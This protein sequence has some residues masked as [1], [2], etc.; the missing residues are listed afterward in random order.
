MDGWLSSD[1]YINELKQEI[2]PSL[3]REDSIYIR[4]EENELVYRVQYSTRAYVIIYWE[5][6]DDT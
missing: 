2:I 1:M 6:H 4:D 5:S 3:A